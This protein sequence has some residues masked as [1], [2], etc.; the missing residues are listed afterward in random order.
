MIICKTQQNIPLT[1]KKDALPWLSE[2]I[3]LTTTMSSIPNHAHMFIIGADTSRVGIGVTLM[4]DGP[5]YDRGFNILLDLEGYNGTV[6]AKSR[7]LSSA[8]A[9]AEQ[10]ISCSARWNSPKGMVVSEISSGKNV[11]RKVALI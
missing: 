2:I 1:I 3:A 7:N 4:Q 6:L 11:K 5:Q 9:G 10:G 8:F